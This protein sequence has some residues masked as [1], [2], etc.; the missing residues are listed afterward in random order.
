MYGRP[1][2]RGSLMCSSPSGIYTRVCHAGFFRLSF[3]LRARSSGKSASRS[4]CFFSSRDLI[5]R[6]VRLLSK[7]PLASFVHRTRSSTGRT[8]LYPGGDGNGSGKVEESIVDVGDGFDA[9]FVDA[10]GDDADGDDDDVIDAF[11]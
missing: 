11:S 8:G 3:S 9:S 2:L 5:S 10:D 6:Y 7:L 4:G 1:R